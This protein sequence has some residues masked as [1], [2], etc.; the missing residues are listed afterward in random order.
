MNKIIH[1]TWKTMEI[2]D[3]I[4]IEWPDSWKNNYPTWDY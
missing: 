2:P 4:N 3:V 1:Q